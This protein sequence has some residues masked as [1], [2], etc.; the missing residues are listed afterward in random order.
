MEL[1]SIVSFKILS[2]SGRVSQLALRFEG[3]HGS[4]PPNFFLGG[5]QDLKIS[6]QN[7]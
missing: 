3:S 6:D 2:S 4:S 5:G 1:F 7:N